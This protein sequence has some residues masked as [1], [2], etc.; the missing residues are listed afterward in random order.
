MKLLHASRSIRG[1]RQNNE[2]ACASDNTLG[3]FIVADGMGGYAGGEVASAIAVTTLSR[4]I[5][6]NLGDDD[7]TWPYGIDRGL[8]L[9]E[10]M[11][12]VASMLANDEIVARRVGELA[13]MGSTV[14]LLVA[15]GDTA[16]ISH[17]GDSRV[18]RLRGATLE[19]LT[20]DHSLAAEMRAIGES[21]PPAYGH[22]VTRALGN[23][24]DPELR[25]EPLIAGDRYLLCTDGLSGVIDN[26][27][28]AALLGQGDVER[29]CRGLVDEAYG[30]GSTDNITAV[31]IDV[32]D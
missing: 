27:E 12:R 25:S 20:R 11:V 24:G 28:L 19:Q 31:V 4:F 22:I 14:A 16:V 15:R 7:L 9:N 8:T 5:S 3:L 6:Q 13:Q 23:G 30:R 2:D 32:I 29:C 26:G 10:N 21:I 17:V 1:R 18:Y